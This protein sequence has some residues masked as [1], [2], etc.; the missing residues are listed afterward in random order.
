MVTLAL[1]SIITIL[2]LII[3]LFIISVGGTIAIIFGGDIIIA[4]FILW[5]IF[6]K[7]KGQK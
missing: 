4:V 7:N 6:F 5:L 1:L 2:A 3:A